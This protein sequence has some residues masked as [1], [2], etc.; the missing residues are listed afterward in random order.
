M[1]DN[2]TACQLTAGEHTLFIRNR[3][4]GARIARVIIARQDLGFAPK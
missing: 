4:S 3:E 2:W 1:A